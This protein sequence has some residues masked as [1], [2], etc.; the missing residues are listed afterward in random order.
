MLES[1]NTNNLEYQKLTKDEMSRRG[2]LGRLVGAC[3][4][5]INPTRNGRKYSEK[6]WENV[7]EDPIMKE[8][9]ENGVCYGELGHPADREETDMEKIA[10][11]LAEVPKKGADGKLRAVFDILN[12]PNG[13]ILKSLCDYGSTLGISS[14]GS[15]DLEVGYDGQ[16]SVNPDTYNCEGFDIVLIPAVKDA[17]LQYVTESFHLNEG[18][19]NPKNIINLEPREHNIT[20]EYGD[21]VEE[22]SQAIVVIPNGMKDNKDG[23]T[24]DIPVHCEDL[25][26]NVIDFNS[27]RE[28]QQWIDSYG[29][30][31]L[32]RIE[33]NNELYATPKEAYDVSRAIELE[34]INLNKKRYN[35]TLRQKLQESIDKETEDH[36]KIMKESLDNLGIDLN[37]SSDVWVTNEKEIDDREPI[38]I[39]AFDITNLSRDEIENII[40]NAPIGST[41]IGIYD[42]RWAKKDLKDGKTPSSTNIEKVQSFKQNYSAP[43][44]S[45]Y[46]DTY[47]EVGGRETSQT[48]IIKMIEGKSKYYLV[49]DGKTFNVNLDEN[50]KDFK[51]SADVS[52]KFIITKI[53]TNTYALAKGNPPIVNDRK[54]IEAN[55][56]E[57]A[58]EILINNGYSED[59]LM[60]ESLDKDSKLT[61]HNTQSG[62]FVKDSDGNIVV[63]TPTDDEATEFIK[64]QKINESV[65]D[66]IAQVINED[67]DTEILDEALSPE[68][69]MDLW[70]NGERR[71]NIKACGDAK[72]NKYLKICQDKGYDEQVKIIEDELHNRGYSTYG[73]DR[74]K[75]IRTDDGEDCLPGKE[76]KVRLSNDKSKLYILNNEAGHSLASYLIDTIDWGEEGWE[77]ADSW[78]FDTSTDEFIV[79][80]NSTHANE[81]AEVVYDRL[82]KK[83]ESLDINEGQEAGDYDTALVDELQEAL[84][85]NRKLDEKIVNL[86]KQ[87]SA[88]DAQETKLNEEIDNLKVKI[89]KLS[90][91]AKTNKALTEKLSKLEKDLEESK[92]A[93]Q[94][95]K[96]ALRETIDRDAKD[97]HALQESINSKDKEISQLKKQLTES[98]QRLSEEVAN[99]KSLNEQLDTTHKDERQLKEKYTRKLEEK[100]VLIEKYKNIAKTAVDNYINSRATVLGVSANEIKNRL[101]ESYSFKDINEVCDDLREY[102]I[103]MNSLPFSTSKLNES[104]NVSV[105]N[106]SNKT[107]IS[108]PDDEISDADMKLAEKFMR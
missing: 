68:E 70:H 28:A 89:V 57:E 46:Y 69:K 83:D 25:D 81:I 18:A 45:G 87:L 15:G 36:Q 54:K 106:V 77:N 1:L 72:L 71:E 17:R 67:A 101:P 13:R 84:E 35:K 19:V 90:D 38:V 33:H 73:T 41:I 6:L 24:S 49:S 107:L 74:S 86:Q 12:T 61:S 31:C 20:M 42:T 51:E 14:R 47:W 93:V 58:K 62:T 52:E 76:L 88:S 3:A 10:V 56:Y 65:W 95:K 48:N 99:V 91:K 23:S 9:I 29:D 98:K 63:E 92:Q 4:D 34:S 37:E 75:Y 55:S 102:N 100:N 2:I 27:I 104:I 59:E 66:K 8:R 82:S 96:T 40:D 79:D 53:G 97:R 64:D 94:T 50:M 78:D 11:C 32:Y 30:S 21:T 105:K 26:G 16:E 44:K 5:I 108:N 80:R 60:I 43:V 85:L 39:N 22:I 7:F 103:N